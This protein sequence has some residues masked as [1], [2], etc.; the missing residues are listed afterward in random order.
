MRQAQFLYSVRMTEWHTSR[1]QAAGFVGS[2]PTPDIKLYNSW[3]I[4]GSNSPV[5]IFEKFKKNT[6]S[7][8]LH[9]V[10]WYFRYIR[11]GSVLKGL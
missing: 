6:N 4:G 11:N 10:L 9:K 2:T 5:R 3:L 8:N 1:T 7:A